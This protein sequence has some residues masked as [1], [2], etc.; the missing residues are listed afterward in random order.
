MNIVIC[1]PLR[2]RQTF[3]LYESLSLELT[4]CFFINCLLHKG[5]ASIAGNAHTIKAPFPPKSA[6]IAI[7][8]VIPEPNAEKT[9]I[10]RVYAPVA[11]ATW[12][13]NLSLIKGIKTT[14][15]IAIPIPIITA[16]KNNQ[17]ADPHPRNQVKDQ[18]MI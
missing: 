15:Q 1:H 13:D 9:L 11:K 5:I 7:G 14:L 6:S 17:T 16:L 18:K 8:A 4:S 12:Q 2:D 3:I 10:L